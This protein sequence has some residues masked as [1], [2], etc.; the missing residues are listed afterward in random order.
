MHWA[1]A[2]DHRGIHLKNHLRE[3][4]QRHGHKITDLGVDS[5][6]RVDAQ[7]QAD[8]VVHAILNGQAEQGILICGT[9]LAMSM[10]ANRFLGIR[11]ALVGDALSA[12]RAREHNNAN[13]LCLGADVIAPATA[14]A[15]VESFLNAA[16]ISSE[17]RYQQ[18]NERLDQN[19]PTSNSRKGVA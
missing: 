6:E 12:A 15:I 7:D 17:A 10:R 4:L 9:G 14:L 8:K 5:A 18:R 11:A 16:F 13:V 2:S 1:I 19:L 3:L